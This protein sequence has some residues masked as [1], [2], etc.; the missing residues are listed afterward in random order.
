VNA[1]ELLVPPAPAVHTIANLKA[2]CFDFLANLL[3]KHSLLYSSAELIVAFNHVPGS[4]YNA[5]LESAA[6]FCASIRSTFFNGD[7]LV[8]L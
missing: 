4:S 1:I 3:C 6:I 5:T 2:R 7:N 8:G